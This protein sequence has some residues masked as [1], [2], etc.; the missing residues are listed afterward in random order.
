MSGKIRVG[1]VG[2]LHES[3]TFV[4]EETTRAEFESDLLLTGASIR[5]R[6]ED[7]HHEV[8]GFLEYLDESDDFEAVPIFLA[9]ALPYGPIAADVFDGLVAEMLDEVQRAGNLAGILAAPH[10]ATVASGC[11]DADGFW[12]AEIRRVAGPDTCVVATIDPHANLS[13]QMVEATDALVAYAS[14]PHLDQ[15]ETGRRA[16]EF[17]VRAVSGEI[18]LRQAASFPRMIVNIQRQNTGEEPLRSWYERCEQISANWKLVSH[19]IVLGFPF[20]DVAEMG[21]SIVTVAD[22][23]ESRARGAAEEMASEWFRIRH[24]FEPGFLSVEKAVQRVS[25]AEAFPVVLLDMGDNVG[26]GSPADRTE[27]A[28]QWMK[29]GDGAGFVVLC[30]VDAVEQA[31]A[32]G[33]E[34]TGEFQLG[35]PADPVGGRFRVVSLGEGKF[36]DGEAHH[37]GFTEFDQGRTAVL[38]SEDGTLTAMVTSRRMAPF[39]LSQ[40]THQGIDP[41]DYRMIAAKG[42]IAPM[43][44]YE[45]IARGGFLHVDSDGPTRADMT[46]LTYRNRRRPLFPFE[47][48]DG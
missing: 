36:R 3:N 33:I 14:N 1:I 41:T 29:Q 30:D 19:S 9:R 28:Q 7:A 6:M 17:L 2:L 24:E 20:A 18:D 22:G 34:G 16:A 43:A 10:G 15:R 48:E 47:D 27:I 38:R 23:D 39:S 13:E 5:E 42:V 25:E 37:G 45:P 21:S 46:K 44:A 11:P 31:V 32:L 4:A 40:L 35:D 12:L 8:G 26:G